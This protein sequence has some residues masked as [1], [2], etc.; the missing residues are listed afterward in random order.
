MTRYLFSENPLNADASDVIDIYVYRMGI[1]AFRFSYATAIG[2]FKS[3]I[4]LML[5]LTANGVTKKLTGKSLF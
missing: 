2:L 1:E 3:I 5:L 4:A